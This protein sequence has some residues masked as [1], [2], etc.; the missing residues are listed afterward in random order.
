MELKKDC[1]R[2]LLVYFEHELSYDN[3]VNVSS[4]SLKDYSKDDI[5]YTSD[6]LLEAG[7][8]NAS[9]TG[10]IGSRYPVIIVKSLTY[11]GHRFLDNV[12]SPEI[13]SETKRKL[14]TL[15]SVS[16]DIISQVASSIIINKLK[17]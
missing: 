15:G 17:N 2:D 11:Q 5:I 8:I 1:V 9:R 3:E 14:K 12:R 6:K 13:W 7:F 10:T 16:L 4:I